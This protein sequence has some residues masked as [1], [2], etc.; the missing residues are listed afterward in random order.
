VLTD[1]E[2][3]TWREIQR[4]LVDDPDFRTTFHP[5]ERHGPGAHHRSTRPNTVVVALT[6]V[7]LLLAGPNLLT[8]A[9]IAD[10]QRPPRSH[11]SP[12][13]AGLDPVAYAIGAEWAPS[14]R[15]GVLAGPADIPMVGRLGASVPPRGSAPSAAA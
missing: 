1:R 2:Q 6:L 14:R 10:R 15:P 4:R 11:E 13:P 3:K 8:D 9:E 12:A 5:I 7:A